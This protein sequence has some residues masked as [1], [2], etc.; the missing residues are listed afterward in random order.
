MKKPDARLQLVMDLCEPGA[1][2]ADIGT[3]HAVLPIALV[4]SGKC[5]AA[6]AADLRE[7]P[8][9]TA[10]QNVAQAGLQAL[11]SLRLSDGLDGIAPQEADCIVMAG[12]GGILIT[13]LLAR[14]PWLRDPAKTLVLQPMTDPP[15]VREWLVQ[16]GFCLLCERAARDG[17]HLYTVMKA[18]Y[19]GVPRQADEAFC[20]VGLLG[21]DPGENERLFLRKTRRSLENKRKGMVLTHAPQNEQQRL[22][23]LIDRLAR[24]EQEDVT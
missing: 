12:M 11:I 14:A 23:D 20:Y 22:T 3:D 24:L 7:G 13:N 6:I 19:D 2:V 16:N 9:S 1:V 8:L 10:R 5:P 17:E 18:R 21:S 4:Q 15:L